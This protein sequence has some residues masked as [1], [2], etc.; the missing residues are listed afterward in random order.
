[1]KVYVVHMQ[2]WGDPELHSYILGVFSNQSNAEIAGNYEKEWR[3]NKY[4]PKIIE[5]K[6]DYCSFYK[7]TD[8]GSINKIGYDNVNCLCKKKEDT[9][10]K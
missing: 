3:A 5:V 1:M 9:D 8:C 2:R 10:C 6:F 4:E 7:C